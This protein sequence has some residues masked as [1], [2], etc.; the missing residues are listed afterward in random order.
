MSLWSATIGSNIESLAKEHVE[1]RWSNL[2]PA[3]R[4]E[5]ARPVLI[6]LVVGLKD[7]SIPNIEHRLVYAASEQGKLLCLRQLLRG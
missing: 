7:S 2:T 3:R 5:A 1:Y 6:R 4:S